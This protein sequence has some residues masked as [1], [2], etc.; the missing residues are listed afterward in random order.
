[1]K[2]SS[3]TFGI[4]VEGGKSHFYQIFDTGV[5]GSAPLALINGIVKVLSNVTFTCT[6]VPLIRL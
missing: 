6:K 3:H 5:K 1:M 4:N 2:P